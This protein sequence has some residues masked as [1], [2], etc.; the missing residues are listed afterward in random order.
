MMSQNAV[1]TEAIISAHG[2]LRGRLLANMVDSVI[3]ADHV[4]PGGVPVR[5]WKVYIHVWLVCLIFPVAALVQLHPDIPHLALTTVGLA[6][7][8]AFY[9]WFMRQHPLDASA[10]PDRGMSPTLLAI[11]AATALGLSL[12]VMFGAA[13]LWLF[14]GISMVA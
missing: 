13:F 7:Y 14:V 10:K 6:S 5:V 3:R 1:S 8:V 12:S 2:P 4:L 11:L 9:T